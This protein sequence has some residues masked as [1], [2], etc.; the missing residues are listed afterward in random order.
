MVK[1]LPLLAV[2]VALSG[3]AES[4]AFRRWTY[5]YSTP[6][7]YDTETQLPI[8][9]AHNTDPGRHFTNPWRGRNWR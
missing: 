4:A 7:T 8:L 6:Y 2:A 1:A 5:D 9:Q 3:C